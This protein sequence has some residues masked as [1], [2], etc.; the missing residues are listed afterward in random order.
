[1]METY[2][3][4]QFIPIHPNVPSSIAELFNVRTLT[5]SLID[6]DELSVGEEFGQEEKLTDRLNRLLE[7]YT[8]GFSVAKMLI[9]NADDAGATDSS[10]MKEATKMP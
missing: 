9:Q 1:M 4:S 6:P 2:N 3:S 5:N 8:D 7:E 10:M